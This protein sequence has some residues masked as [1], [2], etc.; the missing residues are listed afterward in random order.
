[1]IEKEQLIDNGTIKAQTLGQEILDMFHDYAP[2]F[3]KATLTLCLVTLLKSN[4][5]DAQ[6][7]ADYNHINMLLRKVAGLPTLH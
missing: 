4:T 7:L 6:R 1:M 3:A 5:S 2:P